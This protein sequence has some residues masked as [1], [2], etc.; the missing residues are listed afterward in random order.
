MFRDYHQD[1][2][3]LNPAPAFDPSA[4]RPDNRTLDRNLFF[5]Q[6]EQEDWTWNIELYG[7]FD[8]GPIKHELMAGYERY[9]LS[10]IHI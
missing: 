9:K 5:Q 4:L 10:L 3:D 6:T 8:T 7:K 2:L 1:S